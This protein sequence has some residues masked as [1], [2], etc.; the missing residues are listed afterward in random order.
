VNLGETVGHDWIVLDGVH[1]GERVV[2]DG[3]QKV[4]PGMQVNPKLFQAR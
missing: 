3:L 2:V 1:G 4:R